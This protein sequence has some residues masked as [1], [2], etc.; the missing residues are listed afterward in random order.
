MEQR[1][2]A[3]YLIVEKGAKVSEPY[4]TPQYMSLAFPNDDVKVY[5][6]VDLLRDW[7]PKLNSEEYRMKMEIVGEFAR[8]GVDYR[9]TEIPKE[10]L[11]QIKKLYPDTW[12]E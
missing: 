6:P 10:R 5:Y 4:Y 1:Q 12:D 2:Y 7:L 11:E 9:A 8:Q 3:Y